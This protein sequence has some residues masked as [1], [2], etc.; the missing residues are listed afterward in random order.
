MFISC[1]FYGVC[2]VDDQGSTKCGCPSKYTC[3][4]NTLCG[5]DGLTY[6]DE[7][8][9]KTSSCKKKEEITPVHKGSCGKDIYYLLMR[10]NFVAM[11][12]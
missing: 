4:K 10:I 6:G 2:T 8:K 1:E 11:V 7:C 5:S 3:P 12:S 9:M